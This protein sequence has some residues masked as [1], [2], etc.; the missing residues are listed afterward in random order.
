MTLKTCLWLFT[1]GMVM[2][3]TSFMALIGLKY[4]RFFFK[5]GD[6]FHGLLAAG[7]IIGA[8]YLY[9]KVFNQLWDFYKEYF[10]GR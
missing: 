7:L 8:Y 1:R 6:T 2:G 9:I 4:T 10:S 5:A 3:V